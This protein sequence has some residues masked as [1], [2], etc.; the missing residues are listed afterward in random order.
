MDDPTNVLLVVL[1]SAR[2]RNM[3]LYGYERETTPF[4]TEF[5]ERSTLYTQAR[6]PGIHSIASHVSMFTGEH[7]EEH[8]ALHHTA[9]IDPEQ[10][11]WTELHGEFDYATGLFTNNRIVS[12]ASNLGSHFD[13]QFNPEYSLAKRLENTLGNP[14]VERIYFR[15]DDAAS[16]LASL[17]A[18]V[19]GVRTLGS[20]VGGATD[21]V[22]SLLG[23]KK[24]EHG[25]D[26]DGGFKTLYGGEFTDGFLEWETE[27][28]GPWAACLNL[29]DTHSPYHPE[30]EFDRWA[31]EETWRLQ[32]ERKPGVR[33]LL[34]GEGWADL[35]ALEPLYDGTI[36]QADAVVRDLIE[37]LDE[38][39][40]LS[41]TLV[42]VTSD[43]GEAFGEQSRIDPAIRLRGH[44]WGVPEVLTHVPLLVKHPG[45]SERAVVDEV[46][47]LTDLPA[48]MR[49]VADGSPAAAEA[50][51]SDGPVLASTFRLPERK[52]KKYS[53]VD[54]VKQ[55]VGPWRAV[56][57]NHNGSVRKFARHG[58]DAVT[59]D[60]DAAGEA[61]VVSR[62]DDGRVAEVY[63]NLEDTDVVSEKS[64]EIDEELEEQL[65]QLG[66]IR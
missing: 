24:S 53:S 35:E 21:R 44:K 66:Y 60:I 30:P 27:Q 59:V 14:L 15:L 62:D 8:E 28:D 17:P 11:I 22:G 49:A 19:P 43:H 61:T 65:E 42:I 41:N 48:L 57:E 10:S 40:A 23:G 52:T 1:D 3:S 9:Q 18:S 29:M 47:S 25:P 34:D 63:G 38:R 26:D 46:V 2:A 51:L 12:N 4:L 45:Q 6:S 16:R 33:E 58:D 55:Y 54:G 37:R 13:Y 7:V 50:L 20:A 5:A 36:R 64:T 56:Y 31:D 39:D 32:A